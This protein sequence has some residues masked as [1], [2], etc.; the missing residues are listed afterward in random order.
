[1]P[2]TKKSTKP[3]IQLNKTKKSRQPPNNRPWPDNKIFDFKLS[4]ATTAAEAEEFIN[5][6]QTTERNRTIMR[7]RY[8]DG[9]PYS[10]IGPLYGISADA[11]RKVLL[12]LWGKYGGTE[13]SIPADSAMEP[14][15]EAVKSAEDEVVTVSEL[16]G[17]AEPQS[18]QSTGRRRNQRGSRRSQR[19]GHADLCG[20][21]RGNFGGRLAYRGRNIVNP[22]C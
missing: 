15:G 9:K 10:E 2:R 20:Y 13:I 6:I 16:A 14:A 5:T 11:A 19:G 21:R 1:M 17:E 8:I 18:G 7:L 3:D 4:P 22:C 12:G